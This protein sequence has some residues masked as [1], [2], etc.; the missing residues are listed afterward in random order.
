MDSMSPVLLH[1]EDK[2]GIDT[3]IHF[4]VLISYIKK[5]SILQKE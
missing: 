5:L 2:G 1:Q 4:I 3:E